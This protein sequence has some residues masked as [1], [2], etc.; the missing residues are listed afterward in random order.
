M[1]APD[2]FRLDPVGKAEVIEEIQTWSPLDGDFVRQCPTYAISAR[3]A[4]SPSRPG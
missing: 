1:R 4:E 2:V 3:L